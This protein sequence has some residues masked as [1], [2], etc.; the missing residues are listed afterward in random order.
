MSAEANQGK[1]A[2]TASAPTIDD[3]LTSATISR[4]EKGRQTDSNHSNEPGDVG[5]KDDFRGVEGASQ[6]PS[7]AAAATL[8]SGGYGNNKV[9]YGSNG[10]E[11]TAQRRPSIANLISAAHS[12]VTADERMA[13]AVA[14][15]NQSGSQGQV[16]PP[17][18]YPFAYGGYG[19]PFPGYPQPP[20]GFGTNGSG[21]DGKKLKDDKDGTESGEKATSEQAGNTNNS[22]GQYPYPAGGP[23]VYPYYPQHPPTAASGYPYY[24]GPLY[25]NQPGMMGPGSQSGF[26]PPRPGAYYGYPYNTDSNGYPIYDAATNGNSSNLPG[27]QSSTDNRISE[28]SSD[29]G[30]EAEKKNGISKSAAKKRK[31]DGPGVAVASADRP[32]PCSFEGC[33]WSF[34]RLS[35]QRRHLRSHQKPTFHCPYWRSDPTCHRNGGAFNRLDVLKR[36]LRLVHFVQFKQSDSGWCRVCQ[37]MFPTARHFVDH[38][39]KCAQA[40]RPTEWKVDTGSSGS[41][42]NQNGAKRGPVTVTGNSIGHEEATLLSL[43][44][45][46]N[47]LKEKQSEESHGDNSDEHP[48]NS[49]SGRTRGRVPASNRNTLSKSIQPGH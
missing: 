46:D 43:S 9:M 27:G 5:G 44:N 3:T 21:V 45:V 37:K 12:Q 1:A 28:G 13:A 4:E 29:K 2:E 11:D 10:V 22:P 39:E 36:H 6:S 40:A 24:Y 31:A 18:P 49:I 41:G 16:R 20:E 23:P 14:A 26:Y 32:Y 17:F 47:E 42:L 33:H 38:C 30:N 48:V 25:G 15:G 7:T 8:A 19:Q 34:A 35:D